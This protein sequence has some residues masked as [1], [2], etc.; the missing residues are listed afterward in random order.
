MQ[1]RWLLLPAASLSLFLAA[2]SSGT[3]PL[4]SNNPAGTGPFD[5]RGNYIEAWAD[6]PSAWR[7][8]NTQV[9][10][11]QPDRPAATDIPISP[12]MIAVNETPKPA[13]SNSSTPVVFKKPTPSVT[14]PKPKPSTAVAKV[15]PKAKAPT[16]VAKNTPKASVKKQVVVKPK[17]TRHTVRSGDNLYNIAK[18]YGTSVGAIQKANGVKGAMIRP[19]QAL[20]IPR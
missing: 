10:E 16:T 12:S 4:A 18:R 5:S 14:T 20:V 15:T 19:G 3:G 9:A 13:L 8:G 11:A 17:S 2:C 1:S 7:K 6:N